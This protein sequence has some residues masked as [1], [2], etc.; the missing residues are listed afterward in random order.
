MTRCRFDGD[1]KLSLLIAADTIWKG[2]G[3]VYSLESLKLGS[4]SFTDAQF[5]EFQKAIG[6]ETDSVW[7]AA[8]D[9]EAGSRVDEVVLRSTLKSLLK[10]PGTFPSTSR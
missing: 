6:S 7:G 1:P 4:R 5:A 9:S 3:N 2:S 8:R 10:A